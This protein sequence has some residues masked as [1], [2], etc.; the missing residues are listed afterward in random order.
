M[1]LNIKSESHQRNVGPE[2]SGR[3]T[4]GKI[5]GSRTNPFS[6]GSNEDEWRNRAKIYRGLGEEPRRSRARGWREGN[7]GGMKGRKGMLDATLACSLK[8]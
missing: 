7:A 5:K 8:A 1:S 6:D 2:A 3:E 4:R